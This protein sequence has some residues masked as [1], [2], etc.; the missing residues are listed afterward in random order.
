MTL[1]IL[2]IID[3]LVIL[4]SAFTPYITR[5]TELFGV[6]IPTKVSKE[7][8]LMR[9]RV[10]YRNQML[11]GGALLLAASVVQGL[12]T[13]WESVEAILLWTAL[14]FAYLIAAFVL[15]LPKHR[16]MK[17]IKRENGWELPTVPAV[18][19]AD[20]T[21][22]TKDAVSSGW[23]LLFPLILVLT[24]LSIVLIWP[25]VPEQIPVHFDAAG[26]VDSWANKGLDAV[27]PLLIVQAFLAVVIALCFV[28]VRFSKRQV[29]AAN[30]KTSLKQS[31]RY[32][33]FISAFLIAVGVACQL[34][35]GIMQVITLLGVQDIWVVMAPT[36]GLMVLLLVGVCFLMFRVG[37]GGSR[38]KEPAQQTTL[39]TNVD[40]DRYWKLGQFYVN[41]NDPALFVEKRF[42]V[43]YTVNL[44]RPLTWVIIGGFVLLVAALLVVTFWLVG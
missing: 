44:G 1:A 43:G 28:A 24:V 6:S 17:V 42:G 4:G 19:V 32:R 30:P 33:R 3:L 37:Q 26:N 7:P 36:I 12:L 14:L 8:Q 35:V 38:L 21:P 9:L 34:M 31:I 2:I 27:L 29:D 15:Y 41:G 23:L 20:T 10:A 13:D 16:R 18:V 5:T 25:Q 40:D 11:V 22:V 39:N